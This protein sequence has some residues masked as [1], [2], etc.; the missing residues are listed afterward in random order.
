MPWS[1]FS[2]CWALSQLF[3][4]SSFTFIKRLFSSS[5]LSAIKVVSFLLAILI[6]ACASS[7]LAFLMM[8]T[9]YKLNKQG[10]IIQL[11]HTPFPIWNQSVVPCPVLTVAS[12]PGYRFLKRQVR[13]LMYLENCFSPTDHF[14]TTA[15]AETG[16]PR[17]LSGKES[18]YQCRRHWLNPRVGWLR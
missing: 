13:V 18:I 1:L 6:P 3:L 11:W 10:Y 16:L 9:A 15:M 2:E 14:I 8:Y 5:S 7:S 17:W 4:L 12:W